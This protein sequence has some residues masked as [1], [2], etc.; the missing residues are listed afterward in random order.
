MKKWIITGVALVALAGIV[1][2][3]LLL[4]PRLLG[5]AG[6]ED[7]DAGQG[8]LDMGGAPVEVQMGSVDSLMVL[9]ATVRAEPGEDVEARNGGTVTRVWV[10]DGSLVDNGA[11]VVNVAVPDAAAGD[12]EDG[13]GGGTREV[14]LHS[15]VEG[16]VSG[17]EDLRVGDVLEPGAVV[18]NVAPDEFRAVA[19]V[20][21]NDL[22][23]F[24]EDPHDILLEITE[25]PP[26][27]ECEF[28]SLGAAEGGAAGDDGD[29]AG[30]GGEFPGEEF[31]GEVGG[32][33]GGSA[34]LSCRVP[35]D[36]RVFEGVTGKMSIATGG[37]ENVMVIP[38]TA[39]RG[40]SESGEVI[41]IASD[42]TEEV[43]E[44]ELG[45]S[46]GSSVEVVSGLSVGDQVLDPIPL[47]PRFDVPGAV[48]PG[49]ELTEEEFME[50]E[51]EVV[52]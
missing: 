40:T 14:S 3:G 51:G 35:S 20:P 21:A 43:R 2:A 36:L 50:Y 17:L 16:R 37:A 19:S 24:Y 44:V 22:Y 6:G 52:E 9:D 8:A 25:G 30:E 34:E 32:G 13:E 45:V 46:D 5:G 1:A 29:T 33:S 7:M 18:A 47:D 38:V 26:A 41:V 23:R 4:L 48:V 27:A 49:D 11:P 10:S 31:P 12:G 42:G 39:V 15:P 28:L